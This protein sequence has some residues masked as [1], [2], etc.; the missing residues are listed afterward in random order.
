MQNKEEQELP[1]ESDP[2]GPVG[3]EARCPGH[4]WRGGH[5]RVVW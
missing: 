5:R 4:R 3:L 1:G 2:Y